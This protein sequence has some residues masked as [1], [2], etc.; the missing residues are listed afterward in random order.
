MYKR[1][2]LLCVLDALDAA[3]RIA[4]ALADALAPERVVLAVR[5]DRIAVDARKREQKMC[6]RDSLAGLW[7][8]R[9]RLLCFRVLDDIE[10]NR[11]CLLYTSRCV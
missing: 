8:R 7:S 4:V 2:V 1:Q 3:D 10:V 9:A 6:I 11:D 5:Q